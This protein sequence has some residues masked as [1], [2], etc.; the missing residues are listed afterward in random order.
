MVVYWVSEFWTAIHYQ[1]TPY[2]PIVSAQ[3]FILKSYKGL[4][5]SS[6]GQFAFSLIIYWGSM[7]YN[8]APSLGNHLRVSDISLNCCNCAMMRKKFGKK[9]K[10]WWW[11]LVSIKKAG[12]VWRSRV[13]LSTPWVHLGTFQTFIG[14]HLLGIII[15]I[16]KKKKKY[17]Q[18]K[19]RKRI[20]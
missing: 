9:A 19:K 6:E 4:T 2:S 1:L 8:R 11:V 7:Q 13:T 15:N 17:F 5:I 12:I 18:I 14:M 16:N 10:S 20:D 3:H